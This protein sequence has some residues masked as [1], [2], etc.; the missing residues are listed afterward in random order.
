MT[1]TL[2]GLLGL[3][4]GLFLPKFIEIETIVT[5]QLIFYSQV[6]I[7]Q[8]DDWPVGFFYLKYLKI[9]TGYNDIFSLT[10]YVQLTNITKKFS[11]INLKK[12]IIENFNL[13]FVVLILF[14]VCFYLVSQIRSNIETEIEDYIKVNKIQDAY[15]NF[16]VKKM[17]N[18]LKIPLKI[19]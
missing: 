8:S 13:N 6:L 5:M 4:L 10:S 14:A 2:L 17:V 9:A 7:F 1:T 12:T 18:K 11:I 19:N 15:R 3:V 16:N